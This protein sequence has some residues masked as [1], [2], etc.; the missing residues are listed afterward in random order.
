VL[1]VAAIDEWGSLASF[2]NDGARSVDLGAPGVGIA[3]TVQ[4]NGYA[5]YSGTSMA[6]P[7]VA[8]A[9]ALYAAHSGARGLAISDAILRA[10]HPTASLAWKTATGGRLDI[11]CLLPT[12]TC[13][14]TGP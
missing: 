10:A 14:A 2:S 13:D 9:A 4:G 3:S 7:H 11:S 1:S 5:Y 12:S 6:T 8:G